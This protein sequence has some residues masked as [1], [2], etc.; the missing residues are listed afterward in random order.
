MFP[1]CLKSFLSHS[2]KVDLL[3]TNSLLFFFWEC[4]YVTFL[5]E[6]YFPW[7]YNSEVTVLFSQDL[8]NVVPL[9]Y[10]L[11]GWENCHH[12]NYFSCIG[13]AQFLSAFKIIFLAFS[14]QMFDY[15]VSWH[16][17][18]EFILLAIHCLLGLQVYVSPK[19]I[20]FGPYFFKYFFNPALLL[21]SFCDLNERGVNYL[22][23][24][25]D[26]S[27]SPPEKNPSTQTIYKWVQG[28][29]NPC[30]I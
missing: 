1:F 17:V 5:T 4:H 27:S 9:P 7:I 16:G 26:V 10:G 8:K 15:D 14:F 12:S 20:S 28:R 25:T 30:F 19:L 18:L 11:H 13:N 24:F 3:T 6:G 29:D 2:F 22:L 23:L 21:L